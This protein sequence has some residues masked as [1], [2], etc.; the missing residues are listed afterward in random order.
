VAADID[1][2]SG[3]IAAHPGVDIRLL[4]CFGGNKAQRPRFLYR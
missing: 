4:E 3:D 1:V 2:A